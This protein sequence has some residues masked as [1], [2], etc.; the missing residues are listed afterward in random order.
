MTPSRKHRHLLLAAAAAALCLEALNP[1]AAEA[2]R[3]NRIVLYTL[4]QAAAERRDSAGGKRPEKSASPRQSLEGCSP[5]AAEAYQEAAQAEPAATRDMKAIART[6]HA[7][8]VGIEHSLKT[9]E[10]VRDKIARLRQKDLDAGRPAQEDFQYVQSMG[11]LVRYTQVSPQERLAEN[12]FRTIAMMQ[13]RGYAI[14]SVDNKYLGSE[15]GYRGI[16]INARTPSGQNMELQLHTPENI[17][18]NNATHGL[19]ERLR[20][21]DTPE[22]EK[23]RLTE[24]IA[25][26]YKKLPVPPGVM[27]IGNFSAKEQDPA[28]SH[29]K[30]TA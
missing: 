3:L 30:H 22:E 21:T 9:P 6:L 11:D 5:K 25:A 16:H 14:Q 4:A 2:A 23:L 15:R 17:A 28:Q 26:I 29:L 8:L 18:A 13:D 20:R 24:Q 19:Y 1:F 7:R 10:S 12:T 27:A